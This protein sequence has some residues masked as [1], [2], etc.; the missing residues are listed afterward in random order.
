M[1]ENISNI[2]DTDTKGWCLYYI[3]SS[4]MYMYNFQGKVDKE[5]E[6]EIFH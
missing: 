6:Y 2:R 3:K 1:G 5:Y 4:H